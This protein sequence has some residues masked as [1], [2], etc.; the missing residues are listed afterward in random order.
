MTWDITLVALI[1]VPPRYDARV[2]APYGGR[3]RSASDAARPAA[4]LAQEPADPAD[5]FLEGL[6]IGQGDQ[7]EVVGFGPVE[8][9]AVR[10]QEV[11][12][13]QQ[14]DHELL[15]VGDR[16]DLGVQAGEAVQRT[17]RTHRAHTGDLVEQAMASMAC[18]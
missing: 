18:S 3:E 16:V 10:D 13:A 1:A 6:R 9:R 15:V 11:F 4:Q 5:R 7:P 17:A 8:S 14:V 12:G 2:R